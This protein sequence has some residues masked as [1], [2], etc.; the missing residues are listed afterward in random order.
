L[1]FVEQYIHDLFI[2][3]AHA[4]NA[5]AGGEWVSTFVKHLDH[6]LKQRLGGADSL[7][8]FFDQRDLHSNSQLEELLANDR[9]SAVFLAIASRS[10][11]LRP[12][13]QQE[14]D[15]FV[16]SSSDPKRLFVVECLPLDGDQ[17]YPRPLDNHKR[18]QFWRID[19]PH[20]ATPM[21]ISPSF[22]SAAFLARVH[23]LAEQIRL[24]LLALGAAAPRSPP[25][26]A[27]NGVVPHVGHS[28]VSPPPD[29]N[30]RRVLLAQV[31]D[32]LEEERDQVRRYLEQFSVPVVPDDTYPQGGDDFKLEFMAD[33]NR[34]DLFVQLLGQSPG[35][36]PPDLPEGYMWFQYE[37]A[38]QCGL[39]VLQWREPG[40]NVEGVGTPGHRSLLTGQYVMATGLE[41]FK[42]EVLRRAREKP[43]P[44]AEAKSRPGLIFINA[45]QRD[46][47]VAKTMLRE[48]KRHNLSTIMPTYS[49][50]SEEVRADLEENLTECDALVLVYGDT[51][52]LWVRGQLRLFSKL[53]AKRSAP[54]KLL[55]IYTGPPEKQEDLGISIANAREINCG[56][57][58]EMEPL[59]N[60]IKELR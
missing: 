15:F 41:S 20:S 45:D 56:S 17:S 44:G 39:S 11:A 22:E 59:Q 30:L 34:A 58:W 36:R 60:L 18:M 42:A 7:D 9:N 19:A 50:P 54:P 3:Y 57:S 37:A 31:A 35:K 32:D 25:A 43:Q 1:A 13:T 40:L 14:L 5:E 55:A 26:G 16:C 29:P 2:S 6:A 24:K 28:A 10:Y 46:S 27:P 38:L 33:L 12:W 4:D 51:S 53:K 8:I 48:L 49:G 23:D 21:P 47:D 52:P